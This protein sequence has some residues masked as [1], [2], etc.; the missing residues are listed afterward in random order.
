[1]NYLQFFKMLASKFCLQVIQMNKKHNYMFRKL[2]I[3]QLSYE[4]NHKTNK[5]LILNN[6]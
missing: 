6:H 3:M 2:V 1:M 5:I 4:L